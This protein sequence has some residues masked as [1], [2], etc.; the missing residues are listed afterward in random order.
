[1]DD[2]FKIKNSAQLNVYLALYSAILNGLMSQPQ[3]FSEMDWL[4]SQ[5]DAVAI[6]AL[7]QFETHIPD[8]G[9]QAAVN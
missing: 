7:H 6:T 5:A 2:D 8:V 9:P 3:S 4:V 1:M